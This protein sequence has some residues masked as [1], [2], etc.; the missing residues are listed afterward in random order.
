MKA[1]A[2]V[3]EAHA[4]GTSRAMQAILAGG[5]AAGT[6]DI[7]AA[8]IN[9]GLRGVGPQRVLHT[10][11]GGLI[12]RAAAIEGGMKTAA[13]GLA[14]H[15]LIA[16][17]AA[18]VYYAA[19]RKLPVL[20]RRVVVCG[21]LYGVAVYLFMYMVVLPLSALQTKFFNQPATSILTGVLIHIFCVGLPIALAI[22][23]F[24]QTTRH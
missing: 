21:M 1:M 4:G 10:I 20:H 2:Q 11:A 9:S 14:L 15:F 17:T 5:L 7:L 3:D 16:T 18:A 24:A 12:G 19:S 6:L 23:R 13:L 22:R 8:F